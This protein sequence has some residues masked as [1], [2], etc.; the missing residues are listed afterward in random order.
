MIVRWT[1]I[2]N[3][4]MAEPNGRRLG[5]LGLIQRGKEAM[6][7]EV[8]VKGKSKTDAE[9]LHYGK[10]NRVTKGI[11]FVPIFENEP[12]GVLVVA[13]FYRYLSNLFQAAFDEGTGFIRSHRSK[14]PSV[15]FHD[16]EAGSQKAV[17]L[18]HTALADLLIN[19]R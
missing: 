4:W 15:G 9:T 12:L 7:A 18:T 5:P 14:Q 10:T 13:F 1:A 16:Y 11:V 8:A 2:V 6:L 17:L 3:R 19:N